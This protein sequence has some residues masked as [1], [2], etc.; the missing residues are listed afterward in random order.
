MR[1]VLIGPPGAGKGTQAERLA[2]QFKIPRLTT[3][4][5]F[6]QAI[7]HSTPLGKKVKGILDCGSLVPDETV[8][9]LMAERMSAKD[10]AKGFILDGFPR[11]IGQALGLEKWLEEKKLALDCALAIDVSEKE[12]ILRNIGRRQCG[13][14]GRAYHLTFYPPKKED[15]CDLCGGK[16]KQREDDKEGT[17]RRRLEVYAQETAP[18]LQFYQERG[19]LKKIDGA[20]IPD[21]V[22]NAICS[23]I[24]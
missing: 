6:R 13:G 9:E 8:L 4:D 1:I 10:S 18:L 21:Q 15:V 24:K 3:G 14:C 11:T 20:K 19:L 2:A 23:L 22:F 12:A 17:L 5:L 7:Q 16:L